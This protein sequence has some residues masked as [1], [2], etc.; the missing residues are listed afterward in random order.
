MTF[1]TDSSTDLVVSASGQVSTTG[2]LSVI[3]SPYTASGTDSDMFGDTGTWIYSLSVTNTITQESPTS[4]TTDVIG[5]STFVDDLATDSGANGSVDYLTLTANPDLAVSASGQVSTAG[6]LSVAD[7]PYTVSGSDSDSSGD[8]GDWSYSLSVTADTLDQGP[9]TSGFTSTS[10]SADFTSTLGAASGFIGSVTFA[11]TTPGFTISNGDEL[12]STG[13]LSVAGSPY[14]ITGTDSDAYGDTGTW[15]YSL[16]V[17]KSGSTTT[18]TQTSPTTGTVLTSSSG[19]FT[20]GPISVEDNTGAVTFVT[21]K[22]NVGLRVNASGLIST[23]GPLSAGTYGVSGTD[24]D[25]RGDTGTWSYSLSVTAVVETVTFEPNGGAGTMSPENESAPTA[26]S[27]NHFTRAGY[28]FTDWNTSANGSGLSYANGAAFPFSES[29]Q[30]FAQWKR[31]KAPSRTVTFSPNGGA[32]S[33]ASEIDNTPTAISPSS[34][35]RTGYTFLGWN[36]SASGSGQTFEPGSTYSFKVSIV[37]YAQWKKI[38]LVAAHAVRYDANGGSG[39][40]SVEHARKP[41]A[42]TLN[43]FTRIGYIFVDWNTKPNGTGTSYSNG[44]TYPFVTSATLFA[45][46][47]IKKIVPPNP[48]PNEVVV[49]QFTLASSTL[50]SALESQIQDLADEVK[51]KGSTQIALSGYGDPAAIGGSNPNGSA[52]GRKRAQAV[53]V[54]LEGRLTA[55]GLTGWTISLTSSAATSEYGLIVVATLS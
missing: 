1:L 20:A 35:I 39:T 11:T 38:P 5:S 34:F 45:Q 37:L 13:E 19:A 7:S 43:R 36:T 10:D 4:N 17:A 50:S 30:L 22:S 44:S 33:T 21:T 16:T 28:S 12:Q 52:L 54:Y 51:S 47:N 25:A 46:W 3:G 18:L 2:T 15:T 55:L 23:T 29:T 49:G 31:G 48:G 41:T 14:I 32:G 24:S 9:P 6:T 8:S 53:A 40:M 26:L 27:L 42:L